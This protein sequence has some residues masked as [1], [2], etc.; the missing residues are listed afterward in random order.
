[1][2][3]RHLQKTISLVVVGS[4]VTFETGC[5][6]LKGYP[7]RTVDIS[8]EIKPLEDYFTAKIIETYN[9]KTGEDKK[10]YRDEVVH[11]R[12]RAIDLQ[13]EAFEKQIQLEKNSMDM[14]I[15]LAVLGLSGAG[16][17]A[18]GAATKAIL[19]AISGGLTGADLSIDKSLY[20]EKTMPVL[21]SQMEAMRATQLVNIYKGLEQDTSRYPL[22]RA[23]FD[24]DTY[25]K[26]GT[27]P[28]AIVGITTA[29]G[30]SH[31]EAN[32]NIEKILEGNF[33]KDRAGDIL[34]E[35]WKPDGEN[36][37]TENQ[38]RIKTWMESNGFDS[39]A[40]TLFLRDSTKADARVKAISDLGIDKK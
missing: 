1:M 35:F 23:L 25:Y 6:S 32:K 21:F 10:L 38:N 36:I 20:Y 29:A 13:F 11:G 8:A 37:N 31:E 34:R 5:Q 4:I 28:G 7:D 2:G 39:N 22:S 9:K 30:A 12:L 24:I 17:M 16:T 27:I 3:Y 15:D 40:I 26:V 33:M 19:A 18:G 14:G